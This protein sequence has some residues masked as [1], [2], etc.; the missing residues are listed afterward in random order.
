MKHLSAEGFDGTQGPC[1]E[2]AL[3]SVLTVVYNLA[4]LCV[5]ISWCLY[6]MWDAVV[7]LSVWKGEMHICWMYGVLVLRAQVW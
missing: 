5:G 3:A 2:Q 4:V 1:E 7:N 6:T